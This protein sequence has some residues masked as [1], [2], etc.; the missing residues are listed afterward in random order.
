MT[1]ANPGSVVAA[2]AGD[3]IAA[4]V[5]VAIEKSIVDGVVIES[6]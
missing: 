6:S 5:S 1:I 2:A 3:L 4:A